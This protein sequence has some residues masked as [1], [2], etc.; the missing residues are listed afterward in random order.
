MK[1]LNILY[2]N[3]RSLVNKLND[4]AI[5]IND[6]NPDLVLITET[7]CND[8]ITNAM[9]NIPGYNI[10]PDL[11]IDRQDT[12]N[13]IGGG[14]IVYARDGLILKPI[15][16]ESSFNMFARFKIISDEN[17]DDRDLTVTIVYRPPRANS[18]NSEELCK[19][20]QNCNGNNLFIG[21]FNFPAINWSNLTANGGSE[22]F[23]QCVIDNGF[24]Q[25]V[26]F[27]THIRG[28]TLDLVLTNRPENILS[29]EPLGNLSNSDHSIISVDVLFSSKFNNSSEL[30]NDWRRGDNDGLRAYLGEIDWDLEL[31]NKNTEE[32]WQQLTD[33]VNLAINQFIPKIRRRTSNNHQW[34]TKHVKRLV[35]KKQRHYN[36]Y[37]DSGTDQDF[38][39]YNQ[40]AKDCKKAIRQ[41]KKKFETSIAKNGNKRP[42]NAYIKSKTKSRISVGPLK[43]GN[44]LITDNTLMATVLNNQF[45]SVFTNED[46]TTMP[47][48]P[49][50]SGGN[51]IENSFFDTET[52]SKKIK[53]LKVSS[54]SG[55]DGLSSKF[56]VDHVDSLAYP[57]SKIFN[58]SMESGIVPQA[59]R[60]A[61]VTPIYKNK[62]AKSK[63]ENYR[64]ISLTS[65][66]CK[67][68]ESV[69]RDN[70]VSYL[71]LNNLIKNTQHG[72]M[73]K[74]SC[75]TNLLE[76]LESITKILDDGDPADIIYLDFAKAFDK[77]PHGRLINKMKALG[78]SGKLLQWTEAWLKDRRQRTVLNGS[79]SDW[80]EVISGVPQGSVL[81]PLLFVIFINDIDECADHISVILKFAD[82]TKIGNK[83]TTQADARNLQTCLNRLVNWAETWCMSFNTDKCKV[84]H[85]GRN[86]TRTSYSM[87]DTPLAETEQERDIGVIISSNMKPSAQCSEAARRATNILTQV[88]RS[89]LY[90]DKKTFLQLY[91][92]FVRCH[93]EFAV[94][95]WS[96]WTAADID[97]LEK[98]QKRAVNLVTGLQAKT[99]ED[100]LSEIGISTL[101]ERRVKNDMVQT[102]KIINGIDRV[103]FKI[104]FNL[105]GQTSHM[106][107]RN[108]TYEK[109]IVAYRSRTDIRKNFFSSRVVRVWNALPTEVKE[110]RNL[111]IFKQK[112]KDINLT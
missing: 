37:M 2:L 8:V 70:V 94:P 65:I 41:A 35:R 32:A 51:R 12:L 72:F 104:W 88:S 40:T 101:L 102:Y 75:T 44:D 107:T 27:P 3:A 109:N 73:A 90:R 39:R 48:C 55:P 97:V 92:Q 13:G 53:S 33:K 7:W 105:V 50:V 36:L 62:G 71:S 11:R 59:W 16:V 100:K 108:T 84:L 112:L 67:V 99:Y 89:F 85:V 110:A 69:I 61:N 93:L 23:L 95:A 57:L 46:K 58:L 24:D 17:K 77:V 34:M 111:S 106:Q 54:S 49:D 64:P 52:V 66:P 56:L 6:Q 98:V 9:L 18:V 74:K 21:D 91:K 47:T 81:G 25:L 76:F 103:D 14:L 42:F 22:A 83:V 1:T 45:N 30:V 15:P 63:A 79:H 96:P 20:F 31:G 38:E 68:M 82:D 43:H 5:L 29:V 80:T 78:I 19:L 60:E 87:N 26:D 10:E 86:N 4:L 28:N